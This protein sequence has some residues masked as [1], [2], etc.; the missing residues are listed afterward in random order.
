MPSCKYFLPHRWHFLVFSPFFATP[1][2]FGLQREKKV[3]IKSFKTHSTA[4]W[5]LLPLQF[6]RAHKKGDMESASSRHLK[7][8]ALLAFGSISR[9]L[10]T[11]ALLFIIIYT[12]RFIFFSFSLKNYAFL[13]GFNYIA[14]ITCTIMTLCTHKRTGW[15][16]TSFCEY[17][18]LLRMIKFLP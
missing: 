11:P 13:H 8:R 14:Y 12:S 10:A 15:M 2:D 5:N 16:F 6:T 9:S 3:K 1:F 17:C 7:K 4:S 18:R